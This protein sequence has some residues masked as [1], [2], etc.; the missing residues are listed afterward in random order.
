MKIHTL[1][2]DRPIRKEYRLSSQTSSQPI[3]ES[4]SYPLV[5]EFTSTEHEITNIDEL[6]RL[7]LL[8]SAQHQCL[9]KGELARPLVK[10]RRAGT[11]DSNKPTEWIC[12]DIDGVT[13]YATIDQFLQDLGLSDTDYVLQWSSSMGVAGKT[14]LRCH[15]FMLLGKPHHPALLKQWLI[16][17]NLTQRNLASQLELTKS[18]NSLKWPLDVTTCQS[19]KLLYVAAPK[20]TGLP[21]PYPNNRISLV[22]GAKRFA[23]LP[24]ST[25]S[26][27]AL[28]DLVDQKVNELR[29]AGGLKKRKSTK[30]KYQ[31]TT[32]YMANP[33]QATITEIK[34]ERGFVYFN[35]NGGDSWGYYHPEDNPTFIQNFKGEPTYRTQDLLPDYW[36]RITERVGA[37]QPDSQGR[38]FLAFRDFK[39]SDYYNGIYDTTTDDLKISRAKSEAQ[40]RDFMSQ[41]GQPLGEFIP[42]WEMIFDP[43]STTVLD[44]TNHVL[45]LFQPSECMKN[46]GTSSAIPPTILKLL[47]HIFK[48]EQATLDHFLNWLA[49]IVQYQTTT[50]TAWILHGT[51]GTGKGVLYNKVLKPMLGATN[52]TSKRFD[53]LGSEFTGFFEN[54]LL[55]FLDEME[56]IK[57]FSNEKLQARIKNLITEET[58]SVRHM[59]QSHKETPNFCNLLM[60]SNKSE[61]IEVPPNDR[62]YNIT[63]YQDVPLLKSGNFTSTDIDALASELQSFYDYLCGRVADRDLARWPID[64]AARRQLQDISRS[65]ID[66]V[67][68]AISGGQFGFLWNFLRDPK[69]TG[70]LDFNSAQS[71]KAFRDLIVGMLPAAPGIVNATLTREELHVIYDWCVGNTPKSP[72]KFTS[73]LKH[74]GIHMG[75][76]WSNGRTARGV[77]VAWSIE[78]SWLQQATS[79]VSQNLV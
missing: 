45:N 23:A 48:G 42:D 18:G 31:G 60:S 11:T 22:R 4:E 57:D 20:F 3:I 50:G 74:H 69:S 5:S 54:R 6:Y 7:V 12:L 68:D 58:I 19:D 73:L 36:A 75:Y 46:R 78:P 10:E 52:C 17:Q 47:N 28:R 33:E 51:Q 66:Q 32:E 65:A 71:Y 67:S 55:V 30:F 29:Q 44:P 59:Y 34:T 76:I 8:T 1:A 77:K 49:V 41:H 13:S 14:G 53:E 79:E 26:K 2:A 39:T 27:D 24:T 61:P 16:H 62:R 40:L 43:S 64:N 72:H 15:V 21:D 70:N 9:L 35:L 56:V 63:A 25:P 38:I 37:Y